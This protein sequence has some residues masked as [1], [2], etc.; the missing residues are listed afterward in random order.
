MIR[1]L[2]ALMLA[3]I[4]LMP[5][6]VSAQDIEGASDHPLVGRYDGSTIN[7]YR[8]DEFDAYPFP[9][10][11]GGE[12]F[13]TIEG[14]VTRISYI[15]P[16]AVSPLAV[17]RNFAA[18]LEAN[19]FEPV[20]ECQTRECGGI[21]YDL[22][23]FPLPTMVVDRFDYRVLSARLE[24]P[25]EG[26]AYATVIVS[27]DGQGRTRVML[28]VVETAPLEIRMID[29][30]Q[31]Q[32]EVMENGRVALYGVT[33]E[34]DSDAIRPESAP[35][36]AEIAAFLRNAPDLEVVIVGHTDNQGSMEYNLGLSQRRAAAVRAALE[37]EHGVD[38]GRMQ[39]AGAG[40][41]APVAPNTSEQGRALNRRVEIIAR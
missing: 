29:A 26:D 8:F 18:A 20:F 31:M 34:F 23:Q 22:D 21:S 3:A 35:T 16:E 13:E 41:L 4:V 11:P 37:S 24:R 27:P 36:I 17:I 19:G 2:F 33:F 32:S 39:H 30:A 15:I 14:K 9:T 7:G 1:T 12:G 6:A 28:G 10:A 40:F 25:E 38:G 5:L